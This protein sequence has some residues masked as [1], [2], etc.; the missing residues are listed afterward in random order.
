[1]T[2]ILFALLIAVILFVTGAPW[3]CWVITGLVCLF[4]WFLW[5]L[6]DMRPF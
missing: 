6:S 1:M 4:G 5:K 3:Y 2:E